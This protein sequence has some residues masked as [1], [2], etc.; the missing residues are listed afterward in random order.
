MPKIHSWEL[1][2]RAFSFER[3]RR[4]DFV[5]DNMNMLEHFQDNLNQNRQNSVNALNYARVCN[6]VQN[7]FSAKFHNGEFDA[8]RN[9]DPRQVALDEYNEGK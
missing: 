4:Y 6:T 1:M 3:I 7:N 2:D 5:E 9:T 8:P